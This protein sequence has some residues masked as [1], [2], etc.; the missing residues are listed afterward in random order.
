M[1]DPLIV[2]AEKNRLDDL[3]SIFERIGFGTLMQSF[4]AEIAAAAVAWGLV[5]APTEFV[6]TIQT[7]T[8][9]QQQIAHGLEGVPD[10]V[11]VIPAEH[12]TAGFTLAQGTHTAT[13]VLVT[14]TSGVKYF[15]L[16]RKHNYV[17]PE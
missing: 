2:D 8:G 15:V 13:N 16:A 9:S 4:E 10:I 7:G 3:Y 12:G 11:L 17:A 14:A 6:S 5:N 1:T